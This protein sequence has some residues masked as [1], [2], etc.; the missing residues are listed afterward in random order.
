MFWICS[1][2]G[3]ANTQATFAALPESQRVTT[4]RS[5]KK[6]GGKKRVTLQV[7]DASD[8]SGSVVKTRIS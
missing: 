3:V 4:A 5:A 2:A 6:G 7:P 8:L 1:G